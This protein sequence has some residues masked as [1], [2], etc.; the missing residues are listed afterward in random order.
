MK[1]REIGAAAHNFVHSFVSFRNQI[2]GI[3][4]I[5]LVRD[6]TWKVDGHSITIEW[7]PEPTVSS[8]E[9]PEIVRKSVVHFRSLLPSHLIKHNLS[10]AGLRSFKTVFC[11]NSRLALQVRV[12]VVDDRGNT[13]AKPVMF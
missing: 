8:H 13:H 9:L 4:I 10:Q 1:Y 5:D 12:E 11:Y 6:A 2:E 7:L 3:S